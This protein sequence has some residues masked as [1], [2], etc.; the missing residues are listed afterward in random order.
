MKGLKDVP[1]TREDF[2]SIVDP[3]ATQ[4]AKY[5]SFCSNCVLT[6]AGTLK[7]VGTSKSSIT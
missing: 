1:F 7:Y 6:D 3:A 2:D 4:E 5:E